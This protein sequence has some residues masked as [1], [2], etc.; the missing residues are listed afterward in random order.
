MITKRIEI[1]EA[2]I[3]AFL[4]PFKLFSVGAVVWLLIWYLMLPS[5]QPGVEGAWIYAYSDLRMVAFFVTFLY[6]LAAGVQVI[7]GLVQLFKY[8]R[9]AAIWSIAFGVFA[10]IIGIFL[11]ICISASTEYGASERVA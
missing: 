2:W 10:L 8:S 9:K 1:P 11:A 6:F 5:M 3:A 4:F 7:V